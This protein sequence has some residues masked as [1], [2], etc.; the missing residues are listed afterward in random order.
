MD[1][2]T[3][4]RT[5]RRTD[6][7]RLFYSCASATKKENC[8]R[9]LQFSILSILQLSIQWYDGMSRDPPSLAQSCRQIVR[10]RILEKAAGGSI[11]SAVDVG[12]QHMPRIVRNF[13]L[14]QDS[15]EGDN[16]LDDYKEHKAKAFEKVFIFVDEGKAKQAGAANTAGDGLNLAHG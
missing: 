6:G 10:Q 9:Q 11:Y 12:L 5:D 7:Q 4:G 14:L 2:R 1:G 8:C 3:D 15:I 16:W 13:L